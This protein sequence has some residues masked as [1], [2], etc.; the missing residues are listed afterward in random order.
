VLQQEDAWV[1]HTVMSNGKKVKRGSRVREG[2]LGRSRARPNVI[3]SLEIPKSIV[4]GVFLTFDKVAQS[5]HAVFTGTAETQR[6]PEIV[7]EYPHVFLLG[8][9]RTRQ[10]FDGHVAREWNH[11]GDCPSPVP[12]YLCAIEGTVGLVKQAHGGKDGNH[13]V[14]VREIDVQRP[15]QRERSLR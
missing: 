14:V 10:P 1:V 8:F 4:P 5:T 9:V 7:H 2:H 6:L 3:A 11:L 13:Q 12:S 15:V